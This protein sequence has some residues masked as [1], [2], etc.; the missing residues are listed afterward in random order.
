[1]QF[2]VHIYSL[3]V[4]AVVLLL[5]TTAKLNTKDYM[6]CG[7]VSTAI[8]DLLLFPLDTIK[9]T[10]QSS[11]QIISGSQALQQILKTGGGFSALYKGALGYAAIDG[12]GSALFFA[13]FERVKRFSVES[14]HLSGPL[15]GAS[16][17]GTA[18][19]AFGVSSVI[20]G[21]CSFVVCRGVGITRFSINVS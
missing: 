11:K 16:V 18:A 7:G 10:Q 9:V 14:L 4:L 15:L 3:V 12:L 20:L 1:M 21:D 8:T 6:I 13:V 5:E 19:A 17:Y 2:R